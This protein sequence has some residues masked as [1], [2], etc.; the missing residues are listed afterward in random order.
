[1]ISSPQSRNTPLRVRVEN[2]IMQ[3][4]LLLGSTA[5]VSAGIVMGAVAPAKA[6][7]EVVLGGYTEFLVQGGTKNTITNGGANTG[8]VGGDRKYTFAMD[9]EV[10][11][12]A[13]GSTDRGVLYGSKVW[14]DFGSGGLG[15]SA[16]S[17]TT[18]EAA[19]FFS[20]NFGRFELGLEDGAEDVMFVGGPEAQAGTGG[21]DGDIPNINFIEFV[22]TDDAA[23]I[24]YFTPRIAGFQLGGS[25]T[26]DFEDP[27]PAENRFQ[28][29]R[30][31]GENGISAGANWVGALGPLDLTVSGVLLWADCESQCDAGASTSAQGLE[32]DFNDD[33]F[34]WAA[35]ALLGFGGFTLG[36]G[37]DRNDSFFDT[38]QGDIVTVGLKYGFGAAHVSV[39]YAWNKPDNN[40]IDD[41]NLIV[42]S[43]D[44]GILP[45]V[46]LKGD[47][48]YNNNDLGACEGGA[49][50]CPATTLEDIGNNQD[51]T[52]GGVASIQFN[53]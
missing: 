27:R 7:I 10:H 28:N 39:G 18:D 43:G 26:P 53:Y 11:F 12:E 3:H 47:V 13:N 40:D 14:V 29:S 16:F 23:K 45:G 44:V 8:T 51:D 46:V 22:D 36:V 1:V 4:K 19:L 9:N 31:E 25:F 6:D 38:A 2:G 42:V 32:G 41:S 34:S 50:E 17:T 49:Q 5:L 24:T 30:N 35:G 52:W 15:G 21:L 48:S 37:Y 20:G 33:E